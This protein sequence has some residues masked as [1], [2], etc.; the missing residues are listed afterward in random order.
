MKSFQT[1]RALV[2]GTA[3]ACM[4]AQV[5]AEV[6]FS[7]NLDSTNSAAKWKVFAGY[8]QGGD[9]NDFSLQWGVDYSQLQYQYY[10]SASA[11]ADVRNIPAPPHSDGTT[12]GLLVN[13]NKAVNADPNAREAFG[14][15]LYPA[16]QSFSGDYV[17]KFDLFLNYDGFAGT[18]GDTT[19]YATYGLN[20]AGDKVN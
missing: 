19:Q 18:D 6:L 2:F 8:Y 11:T 20:F 9:T 4:A 12:L 3:V 15:S 1:L 7:D 10:A 16:G 13:V 14:L 17:L 5:S